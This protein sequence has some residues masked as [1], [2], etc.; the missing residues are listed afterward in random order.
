MLKLTHQV[1]ESFPQD[2]PEFLRESG[3]KGWNYFIGESLKKFL[4][5]G[6]Q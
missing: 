5:E 4:D 6:K 1:M 3:V 2:I